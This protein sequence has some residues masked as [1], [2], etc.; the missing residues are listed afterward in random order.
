MFTMSLGAVAGCFI[1]PWIG[2]VMGRQ[3]MTHRCTAFCCPSSSGRWMH[4]ERCF[5]SGHLWSARRPRHFTDGCR[6]ISPE[7]FPTARARRS[8]GL[9]FNA[10]RILAAVGAIT[11]GHLVSHYG[12]SYAKAGAVVTLVYLVGMAIIW[13]GKETKGKPLPE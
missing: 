9:S 3:P 4:L 13:L 10:G 11:Q 1:G 6:C 8:Q 5:W 7:L 12:G 2:N